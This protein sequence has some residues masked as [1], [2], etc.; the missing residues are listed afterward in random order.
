MQ[1]FSV[2][3]EYIVAPDDRVTD[4]VFTHEQKWPDE[5]GLKRKVKAHGRR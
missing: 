2:P 4:D 1:E 5:V 3:A